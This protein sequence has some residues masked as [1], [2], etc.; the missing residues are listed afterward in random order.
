MFQSFI[1]A[2]RPLGRL[3]RLPLRIIPRGTIV[4]ILATAA[5]GKHWI[6]GSGPHSCWLGFNELSKRRLL[7]REIYAGSVVYDIGANVGS[8][9]IL[10]SVLVGPTGQVVAFEPMKDNLDYLRSHIQLNRLE[11]VNVL[12]VAVAN[13]SGE[14]R[15]NPHPDRLQGCLD[16]TGSQVVCSTT[17]DDYVNSPGARPPNFLKIDVE[18]GEGAILRGA[19]DVLSKYRPVIFLATHGLEAQQECEELLLNAGYR[20]RL[21]G[22]DPSEWIVRQ[23]AEAKS[24]A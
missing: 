7:A 3:L 18:G 2:E 19:M 4:P 6:I 24:E 17:L 13:K 11:N 9:T 23:A 12:D 14:M 22:R 16:T 5:K 21:I 8:Y 10:A 15:F 1:S 20:M